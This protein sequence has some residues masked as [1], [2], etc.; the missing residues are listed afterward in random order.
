MPPDRPALRR[1]LHAMGSEMSGRRLAA[2]EGPQWEASSP[3]PWCTETQLWFEG[4]T[5]KNSLPLAPEC[6]VAE[7]DIQRLL[8]EPAPATS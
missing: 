3:E 4:L 5:A 1:I 8:S 2:I 7:G 6:P